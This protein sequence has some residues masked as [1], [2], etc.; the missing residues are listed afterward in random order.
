M[1]LTEY[2]LWVIDNARCQGHSG[3]WIRTLSSCD[4]SVVW[5]GA[6][7]TRRRYASQFTKPY[8]YEIPL[9]SLSLSFYLYLT[10]S[11]HPSEQQTNHGHYL[12][13]KEVR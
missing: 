6:V 2:L 13:Y 5:K 7:S 8:V 9:L 1:V 12:Y 4:Y 11:P 10:L 3:E